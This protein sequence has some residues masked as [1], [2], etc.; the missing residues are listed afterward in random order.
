MLQIEIYRKKVLE[1]CYNT[2]TLK[3]NYCG[4]ALDWY[5]ARLWANSSSCCLRSSSSERPDSSSLDVFFSRSYF[6]TLFQYQSHRMHA[7]KKP[8]VA[9][10]DLWEHLQLQIRMFQNPGAISFR[11]CELIWNP[12]YNVLWEQRWYVQAQ[13]SFST[14]VRISR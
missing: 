4:W 9:V 6:T 11:Q 10:C 12:Y 1:Y 2:F 13:S 5:F 7:S 8:F 14:L 3:V